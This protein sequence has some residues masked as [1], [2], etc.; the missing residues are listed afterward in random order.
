MTTIYDGSIHLE[1]S[2]FTLIDFKFGLS[3]TKSFLFLFSGLVRTLFD[4]FYDEDLI[5][6]DSF[7]T[8]HD[9]RGPP[10]E[11]HGKG[12]VKMNVKDFFDWLKTG[13]EEDAAS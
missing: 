5:S 1:I 3:F 13:N 7:N 6:E 8:W 10:E 9:R 4:I 2:L 12:I 11:Q